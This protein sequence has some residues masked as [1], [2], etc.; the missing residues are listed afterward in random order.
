MV[1]NFRRGVAKLNFLRG[2]TSGTGWLWCK[3][4]LPNFIKI[5]IYYCHIKTVQ[6]VQAF[7][8]ERFIFIP[9]A[10]FVLQL[11]PYQIGEFLFL[12]H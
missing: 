9:R 12:F 5:N 2:P 8:A 11:L 7:K 4:Q 1:N 6:A 10:L 3:M